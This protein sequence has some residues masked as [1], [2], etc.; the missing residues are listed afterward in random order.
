MSEVVIISKS[1][2]VAADG[3]AKLKIFVPDPSPTWKHSDINTNWKIKSTRHRT[4]GPNQR[5]FPSTASARNSPRIVWIGCSA[6]GRV[7]RLKPHARL[8]H[9]RYPEQNC[10]S[11]FHPKIIICQL[12]PATNFDR[13]SLLR[14][15]EKPGNSKSSWWH[16]PWAKRFL[17]LSS[18]IQFCSYLVL[19][20]HAV[21]K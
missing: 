20:C 13:L 1:E 3:K 19:W 16:S 7:V 5:S 11:I 8:C 6:V 10:T 4:G 2:R 15:R 21:S 17:I 12:W 9:I 18:P 14:F